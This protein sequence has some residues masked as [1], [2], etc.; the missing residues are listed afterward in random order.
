[1]KLGL[2]I[3]DFTAPGGKRE[4]ARALADTAKMAEAVGFET[5]GVADHVWQHPFMGGA[6][7]EELEVYS[8]LSFLAAHTDRIFHAPMHPGM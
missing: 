3:V 6:E 1:M 5:I 8:V 4:L 2:Q 7:R